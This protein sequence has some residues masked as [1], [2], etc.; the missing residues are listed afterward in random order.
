MLFRSIQSL[1]SSWKSA[2][3]EKGAQ[4]DLVIDRSDMTVNLCEIK[5]SNQPFTITKQ[6]YDTLQTKLSDFLSE[7]KTRKSIMTTFITTY[8]LKPNEYSSHVQSEVVLDDLFIFSAH[9]EYPVRK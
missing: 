3:S 8:G 5:Y 2:T 1:T 9:G 6:Y 4:I 7:T